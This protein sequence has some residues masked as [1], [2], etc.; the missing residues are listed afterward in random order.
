MN[1]PFP[2]SNAFDRKP[3]GG[4]DAVAEVAELGVKLGEHASPRWFARLSTDNRQVSEKTFDKGGMGKKR[5]D[6]QICCK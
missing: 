5:L 2:A 4:K 6:G 3:G 1:P